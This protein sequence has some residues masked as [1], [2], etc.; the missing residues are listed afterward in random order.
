[1]HWKV[2]TSKR[3]TETGKAECSIEKMFLKLFK[4]HRKTPTVQLIFE[5]KLYFEG[6]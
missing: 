3:L 6:L 2:E 1:M 4:I 5:R